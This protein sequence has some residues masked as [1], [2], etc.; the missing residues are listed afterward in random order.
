MK[1]FTTTKLIFYMLA[2]FAAGGATGAMLATKLTK[3]RMYRAPSR[4]ELTS[5]LRGK[6]VSRL[7]LTLDQVNKIDP[8][9]SQT[10]AKLQDAHRDSLKRTGQIMKDFNARIA[11]ELTPAQ[12][13]ELEKLE[14]ERQEFIRRKCRSGSNGSR[15][16]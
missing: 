1:A 8:I 4:S 2:L 10:A 14:Q 3:D 15:E 6:L 13:T 9:I 12:Q 16:S 5:R 11:A 7:G